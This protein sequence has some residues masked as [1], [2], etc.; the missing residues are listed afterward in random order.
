LKPVTPARLGAFEIVGVLGE[1]GSAIVYDARMNDRE[2]ALKVS[3]H[4]SESRSRARF[5]EEARL[6]RC[7]SHPA[8]VEVVEVDVLP[9][10]RPYL[11]LER[12]DGETLAER[13]DRGALPF[14]QALALFDQLTEALEAVH[15]AGL[16]HR[17]LKPENILL[18]D[19]GHHLKLLDLGIAKDVKTGPSTTTQA[20]IVR[21]TPATMAPERFLGKPATELSE[22]YEVALL[23]YAMLVGRL[24]WV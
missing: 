11:A 7:V 14:E 21:G 20:G 19:G 15:E 10:G 24:P 13:L 5:L 9:D 23:L 1:G 6:M 17:D 18:V 12:L 16:L 8:M 3:R 4:E 22:V 2:I